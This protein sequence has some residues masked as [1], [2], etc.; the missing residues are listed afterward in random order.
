MVRNFSRFDILNNLSDRQLKT[1]DEM[2]SNVEYS[3][4]QIKERFGLSFQQQIELA[5]KRGLKLR[6]TGGGYRE[7]GR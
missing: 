4:K 7:Q 3:L 2:Y 5:K 6:G 1:F